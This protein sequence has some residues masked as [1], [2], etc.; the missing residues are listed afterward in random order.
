MR[1]VDDFHNNRPT[2]RKRRL[3]RYRE[4]SLEVQG[5]AIGGDRLEDGGVGAFGKYVDRNGIRQNLVA[6]LLKSHSLP[7]SYNTHADFLTP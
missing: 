4:F 2:Q 6:L 7:S 5:L 1:R 3:S